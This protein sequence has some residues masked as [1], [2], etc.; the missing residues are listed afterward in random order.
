MAWGRNQST[1]SC[2]VEKDGKMCPHLGYTELCPPKLYQVLGCRC[3]KLACISEACGCRKLRIQCTEAC[4]CKDM[5]E[6]RPSDSENTSEGDL[7]VAYAITGPD[8][9]LISL[10]YESGD[11]EDK[12]DD[13]MG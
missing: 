1:P 8:G 13:L 6:N 12:H 11:S 7:E 3:T 9:E 4:N 5:C 10:E 2:W